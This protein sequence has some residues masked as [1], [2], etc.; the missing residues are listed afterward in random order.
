[1]CETVSPH[2]YSLCSPSALA[3]ASCPLP[4][5]VPKLECTESGK[6]T[7]DDANELFSIR[8]KRHKEGVANEHFGDD[9]DVRNEH[10]IHTASQRPDVDGEGVVC[11]SHQQL[12]RS[13]RDWKK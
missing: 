6:T 2:Y 9:W 11:G 12:G 13:I 10:A 1:M 3:F 8:V 7:V 5:E 4:L